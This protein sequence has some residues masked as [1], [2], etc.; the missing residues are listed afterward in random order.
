MCENP[1]FLSCYVQ[2]KVI[3]FIPSVAVNFTSLSSQL[4][5]IKF[6]ASV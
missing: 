3:S 2:A 1:D 5:S 6:L 4:L